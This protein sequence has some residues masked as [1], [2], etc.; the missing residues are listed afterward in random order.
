MTPGPLNLKPLAACGDRG[1]AGLSYGPETSLSAGSAEGLGSSCNDMRLLAVRT[2]IFPPK[3]A[4]YQWLD[5]HKYNHL[6]LENKA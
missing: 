6:V 3:S 1:A 5:L 4:L 2:L